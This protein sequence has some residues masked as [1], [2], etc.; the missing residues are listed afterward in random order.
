M[1]L[2]A[3]RVLWIPASV[4]AYELQPLEVRG[5]WMR[6]AV[7]IPSTYCVG[8]EVDGARYEGWV[9]WRDEGGVWLWY[10]TRGC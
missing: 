7:T 3:E 1:F 2:N 9:K 6:V 4:D 5:D 10:Y 8:D